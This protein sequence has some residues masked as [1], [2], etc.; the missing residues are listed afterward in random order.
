MDVLTCCKG[1]SWAVE[2]DL[3]RAEGFEFLLGRCTRCDTPWMNVFCGATGVTG[4]EPVAPGDIARIRSTAD[5]PELKEL[6][7]QWGTKNI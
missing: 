1:S 2:R 3:G 5:G 7:R 6:M 4:Y